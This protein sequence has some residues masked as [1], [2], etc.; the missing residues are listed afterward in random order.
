MAP[1]L[2]AGHV[3][4]IMRLNKALEAVEAQAEKDREKTE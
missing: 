2:A 1:R 3:M 4:A